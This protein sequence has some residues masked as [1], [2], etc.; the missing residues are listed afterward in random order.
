MAKQ[1]Q[2]AFDRTLGALSNGKSQSGTGRKY[3]KY[4]FRKFFEESL[5]HISIGDRFYDFDEKC[6]KIKK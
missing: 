1:T 4:N 5:V 6:W 2:G 3:Q